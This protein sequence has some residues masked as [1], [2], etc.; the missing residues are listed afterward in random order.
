MARAFKYRTK[1]QNNVHPMFS[2]ITFVVDNQIVFEPSFWTEI[3]IHN[4]KQ[5]C[6]S[7]E[8]ERDVVTLFNFPFLGGQSSC[9]SNHVTTI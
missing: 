4:D 6:L 8:R 9:H 7:R 2:S 1:R 5:N 3:K